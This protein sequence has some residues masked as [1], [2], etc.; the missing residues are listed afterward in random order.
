MEN[1]YIT[2]DAKNPLNSVSFWNDRHVSAVA[3]Y[4]SLE[5]MVDDGQQ[6]E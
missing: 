4:N 3:L 5:D 6:L 1:N 2:R